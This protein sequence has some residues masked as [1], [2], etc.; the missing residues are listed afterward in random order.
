MFIDEILRNKAYF[1]IDKIKGGIVS[2]RINELNAFDTLEDFE[3][4]IVINKKLTLLLEDVRVNTAF[5]LNKELFNEFPIINKKTIIKDVNAFISNKY[6]KENLVPVHTSGSYGTPLTYYLTPEKKKTQLAEVI[7]FGRKSGYDVGIRHGYFRSNPHKSKFK[8]WLQNE[9]FF[10]SKVLNEDFAIRGIHD[11]KKDKLKSLI[12]FPSAIAFL[13]KNCIEKGYK[14]S[15][16]KVEG[17]ITSSENLTPQQRDVINKAFDCKIHSRYSTEELGVIGV[18]YEKNGVFELNT[19]NYI[20]E[21]L[22]LEKDETV[23]IGEIGRIVVTDLY[24]N[25]MP[26]VRYETG[27]LGVLGEF[28]CEERGWAKTISQLSGRVM[29]IIYSTN[30]DVLYPLYFDTIMDEYNVFGQYQIIQYTR[31]NY[32]VKL[33]PNGLFM[34]NNFNKNGFI[35]KFNDWLGADAIIEIEFVDDI[36]KLPSGKRPY[37]INKYKQ[38]EM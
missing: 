13:A 3:K 21:V 6:S 19:C 17:V 24:S 38:Y 5:Y 14:A 30:N 20:I 1:T 37:I 28:I 32:T 23:S 25:A 31:I 4:V 18:Q 12:G 35:K 8:F 9:T 33:V 2:K 27:D 36:E 16:F 26:L 15:D 7:L 22:K 11:L 34:D 10:A 29:Q